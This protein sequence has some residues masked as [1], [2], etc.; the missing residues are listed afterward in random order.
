MGQE[1]WAEPRQ[2][3]ERGKREA[4]WELKMEAASDKSVQCHQRHCVMLSS[5]VSHNNNNNL[6]VCG[7]LPISLRKN[8][9]GYSL[10][11]FRARGHHMN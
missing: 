5:T 11:V 7:F 9:D 1:E 8:N 10:E 2:G 3:V 4:R 6:V